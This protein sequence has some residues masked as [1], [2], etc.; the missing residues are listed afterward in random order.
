MLGK[1]KKLQNQIRQLIM[2]L[3]K[4]YSD[5]DSIKA[6]YILQDLYKL[7]GE[8]YDEIPLKLKRK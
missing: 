5:T 7:I 1:H 3:E 6:G 4:K 8:E 2:D